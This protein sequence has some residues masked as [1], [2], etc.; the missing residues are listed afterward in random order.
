MNRLYKLSPLIFLIFLLF[1]CGIESDEALE[2]D[3]TPEVAIS[4]EM[5]EDTA[6][7]VIDADALWMEER[8]ASIDSFANAVLNDDINSVLKYIEFPLQRDAPIPAIT[9]AM[10]F[11]AYYATLFDAELKVKLQAHLDEPDI[12]DMT[13]SNGTVGI[14]NGLIWFNDP[15]NSIITINYQS[16]AEKEKQAELEEQVRNSMHPILKKYDYN[17]FLGRTEEGLFRIDETEKGLRYT[18]WYGDQ[19][20]LDEPDFILWNGVSE[21]QGTA[22]GWRTS[23]D[24][25]DTKYILDQVDMCENPEDCGLFLVVEDEGEITSKLVVTEVLNP[26][27]ELNARTETDESLE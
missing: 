27:E 14:L 15:A 22:G 25:V 24:N 8:K 7:E 3:E 20:M 13:G 6:T 26:F 1:A 21:K 2:M 18:S 4:E 5:A 10:E 19:N 23:F 17:V 9:N 12:M 11:K 16:A